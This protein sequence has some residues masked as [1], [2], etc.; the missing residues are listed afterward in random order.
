MADV[1]DAATRS[2]NMRAIRPQGTRTEKQLLQ[3]PQSLGI[4]VFQQARALPGRPVFVND[5]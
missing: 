5:V 3:L 2:K 1:H 4:A